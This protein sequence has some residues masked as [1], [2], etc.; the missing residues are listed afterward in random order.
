MLPMQLQVSKRPPHRPPSQCPTD[1]PQAA[2]A[3][4]GV[5]PRARSRRKAPPRPPAA[6]KQRRP[7]QEGGD[8]VMPRHRPAGWADGKG[9]RG[10]PLH[11]VCPSPAWRQPRAYYCPD[12]LR[13]LLM[14]AGDM[15]S[16]F[17]GLRR[18]LRIDRSIILCA[19]SSIRP[20]IRRKAIHLPR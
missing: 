9:D 8:D 10:V 7:R 16:C 19:R 3:S 6:A 18:Y 20:S 11:G 5:A 14:E 15:R 4:G 17:P 1:R 13:C 2:E 12:A